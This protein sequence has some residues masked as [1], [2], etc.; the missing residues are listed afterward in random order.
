MLKLSPYSFPEEVSSSHLSKDLNSAFFEAGVV[1]ENF[2][3]TPSRG[4]SKEVRKKYKKIKYEERNNGHTVIHRFA[5]FPEGKSPVQ[6]AVRYVLVNCVQYWKSSEAKGIDIIYS[7]STPPTQGL[8]CGKVKRK[9]SKHYGK[10]VPYM[11]VLQDVFPDSL[12]NAGMTK[13]GGFI[14]KAGRLLENYTYRSA[15]KIIVISNDIKKNIMEKGV[16]EEKIVVIPNW[17][18]TETVKPV[19]RDENKLFDELNIDREGFYVT[20]AGNLGR[21]QSIGTILDAAEALKDRADIHFVI[22]GG[23]SGLEEAKKRIELLPNV[24]LFPLLPPQRVPEVYSL[25][26]VSIVTCKKGFG[27]GAIPSKTFSIMATGTPILLSF[28]RDS[29]LWNLI[30]EH[31]CGFV[32]DAE[33]AKALAEAI[34]EAREN[35]KTVRIKGDNALSLVQNEYSKEKSVGEYVSILKELSN[36]AQLSQK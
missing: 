33:N 7:M 27:K 12:V 16:P 19:P 24:S 29:E 14:W 34:I 8:L 1:V 26:D 35:P 6:R 15:D 18:D 5:M 17:I 3:P 30:E 9:L 11:Y 36:T 2:V 32:C 23:G 22:F 31:D 21:A 28:D 10:N 13:K 4:I 20:Y 25:G